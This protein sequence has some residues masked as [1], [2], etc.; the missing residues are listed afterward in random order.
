MRE[1][2]LRSILTGMLLGGVLS[3]SNVYV[4]LKIGFSF[5]VSITASILSFAIWATADRLVDLRHKPTILE[6]N[7]AQTCA[8]AA[9]YMA[10]TGLN[11]AIPALSMMAAS[12]LVPEPRF[13]MGTLMIWIITIS[14]LGVLTAVALKR[15][16]ID[17]EQLR[18]PSGTACAETLRSMYEQGADAFL[19]ARALAVA[20]VAAAGTK[21]FVE[22]SLG[23]KIVPGRLTL[24]LRLGRYSLDDYSLGLPPSLLLIGA[25]ALVG[26][27][28]GLSM[29]MGALLDY[30]V[31]GPWLTAHGA[32][33]VFDAPAGA[34]AEAVKQA[35]KAFASAA[36]SERW[37]AVRSHE[38]L[39]AAIRTRWSLWPGTAILVSAN[40]TTLL[41]RWRTFARALGGVRRSIRGER[42]ESSG[43][44]S[45]VPPRWYWGGLAVVGLACVLVQSAFFGIRWWMGILSVLAAALL[46]VVGARAVGETDFLPSGALG[47]IT[48]L[49]F[50]GV[51]PGNATAN[52]MTANVTAGAAAH[53]GE[54]LTDIKSGH[55]L[56]ASPR[57]QVIAQL[58]GVVVGAGCC[59]PA[60][61]FLVQSA[62]LGSPELPAPAAAA[63]R[64]MAEF[65]A[66][67]AHNLPLFAL[68]ASIAAGVLGIV[69]AVVDELWPKLRR[70]TP[71][72]TGIGLAFVIDAQDSLA[73][74]AG[75][76]LAF[77]LSRR[78]RAWHERYGV[79]VAS[80]LLAGEGVM[81]VVVAFLK[82][83]R[84]MG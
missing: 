83:F 47:K 32:L 73:I 34:S 48:Q 71:S 19:K 26:I 14:L 77:A 39:A 80:G 51:A 23:K 59:V 52:L 43:A 22:S 64:G 62:P 42:G 10:G 66:S 72:A 11:N 58:F 81:G 24:P 68:P 40:L 75:A 78:R 41:F 60:Y 18:F 44:S 8:G 45:E 27:K 4:G 79:S 70:W 56:G 17:E 61:Q 15:S 82:V 74:F 20:A 84:V 54:L 30:G 46:G 53:A 35:W 12:G 76:V 31:V 65:L 7:I 63:W 37:I 3:V 9:G 50:S 49:L 5:G 57:R 38:G 69:I 29:A 6:S 21:L 13:S 2:T 67:G 36:V 55:L 16:M 25:G 28:V 33:R 1:L